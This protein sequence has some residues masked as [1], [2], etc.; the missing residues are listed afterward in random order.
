MEYFALTF[1]FILI[2]FSVVITDIRGDL[3]TPLMYL[4]VVEHN[5][6]VIQCR[7]LTALH[8]LRV[9][10]KVEQFFSVYGIEIFN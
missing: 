1:I 3:S 7:W 2:V 10:E 6:K 9:L 8:D 5:D 4:P